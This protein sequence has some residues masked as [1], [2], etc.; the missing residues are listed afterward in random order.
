[1]HSIYSYIGNTFSVLIE[2][3]MLCYKL[4]KVYVDRKARCSIGLSLPQMIEVC[5]RCKLY[6]AC[7]EAGIASEYSVC[8]LLGFLLP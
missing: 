1:M 7:L 8:I 3:P 6:N 2:I 4:H 5:N